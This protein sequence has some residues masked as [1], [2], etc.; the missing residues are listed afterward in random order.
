MQQV[1]PELLAHRYRQLLERAVSVAEFI[2]VFEHSDPFFSL[3]F[4]IITVSLFPKLDNNV[5]YMESMRQD[6]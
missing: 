3:L 5:H 6:M 4:P 1:M 2:K